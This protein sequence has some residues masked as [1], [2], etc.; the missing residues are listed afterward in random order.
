LIKIN[1]ETAIVKRV[2]VQERK[3]GVKSVVI[4]QFFGENGMDLAG[5]DEIELCMDKTNKIVYFKY[6]KAPA[7]TEATP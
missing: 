1:D 6:G 4:P 7:T 3:D 2:I 5:G